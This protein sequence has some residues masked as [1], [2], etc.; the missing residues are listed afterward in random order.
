MLSE[1]RALCE[2]GAPRAIQK[3]RVLT[4]KKD[5]MMHPIRA[6]SCIVVLGKHEDRVWTKP[7]KYAPVLRPDSMHLIVSMATECQCFL[8]QGDC[9]NAFCQSILPEDEITIV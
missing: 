2:K 1:Y 8:K 7:E 6:K 9:K 3:I 4:I 5:K